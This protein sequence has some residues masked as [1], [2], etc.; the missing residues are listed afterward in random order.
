MC[1]YYDETPDM[2]RQSITKARTPHKCDGCCHAIA[3]GDL[4]IR[5][6]G[7]YDGKFYTLYE[8][9]RCNV[10]RYTIHIKELAD[11]CR[12]WESWPDLDGLVSYF[13]DYGIEDRA[14]YESG[15]RWLTR[16]RAT[17]NRGI[18]GK[19]A[20]DEWASERPVQPVG[21]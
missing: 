7:L 3:P 5:G 9:G 4:Y 1:F 8:C 19:A 16:F 21:E 13:D 18:A 12:E 14:S 20:W 17:G 10:D 11:G 6:D 15:Q 2:Y